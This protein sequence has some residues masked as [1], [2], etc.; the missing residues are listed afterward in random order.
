MQREIRKQKRDRSFE[1]HLNKAYGMTRRQ[2]EAMYAAQDGRCGLCGQPTP[3]DKIVTDH[4]HNTG[5]VRGLLCQRCNTGLG[6][7]ESRNV[8]ISRIADWL[9]RGRV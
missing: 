3:Y 9:E 2:H 4:D 6:M 8:P 5:K 7:M 1:Y